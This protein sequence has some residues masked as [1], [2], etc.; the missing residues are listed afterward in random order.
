MYFRLTLEL[1]AFNTSSDISFN[2]MLVGGKRC[3]SAFA[4]QLLPGPPWRHNPKIIC[5]VWLSK[6]SSG[7]R[8]IK[9]IKMRRLSSNTSGCFS[10]DNKV[11]S[12]ESKCGWMASKFSDDFSISSIVHIAFERSRQSFKHEKEKLTC[13]MEEKFSTHK[14]YRARMIIYILMNNTIRTGWRQ[15]LWIEN[16]NNWSTMQATGR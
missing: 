16:E 14:Y 11:C 9:L 6:L 10:A 7:S 12:N 8:D 2:T 4:T 1:R 13:K 3:I 5:V 15:F